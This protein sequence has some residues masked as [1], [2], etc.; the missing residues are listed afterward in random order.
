MGNVCSGRS[1]SRPLSTPVKESAASPVPPPPPHPPRV[2]LRIPGCK[3]LK[4]NPK[5][6]VRK[7]WFPSWKNPEDGGSGRGCQESRKNPRNLRILCQVEG[8]DGGGD[9]GREGKRRKSAAALMQST[10]RADWRKTPASAASLRGVFYSAF[11]P[12]PSP[13]PSRINSNNNNNNNNNSQQQQQHHKISIS[14]RFF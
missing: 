10:L 7:D 13:E 11:R 1:H 8:G 6:P 12:R 14:I 9:G 5:R 4:K 3:N 2:R